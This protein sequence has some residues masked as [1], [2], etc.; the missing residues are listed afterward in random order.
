MS[1]QVGQKVVCVDDSG[2]I[3]GDPRKVPGGD[4][5]PNMI[6]RGAIYTVRT[7]GFYPRWGEQ[8]IRLHEVVNPIR[9]YIGGNSEVCFAAH[10]FRPLIERKTD[11]SVFTA[12]LNNTPAKIKQPEGRSIIRAEGARNVT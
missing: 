5:V 7:V 10:R 6:R 9:E 3:D 8:G 12:L 11:I 4:Y 2:P 1:F